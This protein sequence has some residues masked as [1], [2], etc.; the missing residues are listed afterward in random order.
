MNRRY[1]TW[2]FVG[3][4]ALGLLLVLISS[5]TA[6]GQATTSLSGTVTDP[7]GA[8][9]AGATVTLTHVGTR[10]TRTVTT[11]ERGFFNFPQL[12]P[13]TYDLRVE[14]T[15]FKSLIRSNLQLLVN[16]PMTLDLQFTEVGQVVE[17]VEVVAEAL[18]NKTDASIGNPFGELQI[19][20]L[21]LEARN[22]VNLLSLS[23]AAGAIN[24]T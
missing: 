19:R 3:R 14:Q 23:A 24:R 16:L 18:I 21:P 7:N 10:A 4:L 9:V 12:P 5:G 1:V 17:T 20:Q 15:G 8:V 11:N 6:L 13:G 2:R 22:V